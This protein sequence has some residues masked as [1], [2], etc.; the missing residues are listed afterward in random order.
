[1]VANER[2][3]ENASQHG[4]GEGPGRGRGWGA[5]AEGW[6]AIGQGWWRSPE[7]K[8][9]ILD[10]KAQTPGIPNARFCH[11]VVNAK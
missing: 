5:I 2:C 4:L 9:G 1:L 7:V 10:T 11:S 6:K 8:T 3:H